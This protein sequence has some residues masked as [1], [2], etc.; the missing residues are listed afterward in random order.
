MESAALDAEFIGR[1]LSVEDSVSVG[2]EGECV[3]GFSVAGYVTDFIISCTSVACALVVICKQRSLDKYSPGVLVIRA[4]SASAMFYGVAFLSGGLAHMWIGIYHSQ[5]EMEAFTM[6]AENSG[7]IWTWLVAVTTTP[8]IYTCGLGMVLPYSMRA[9]WKPA[10]ALVAF[11][12]A[13]VEAYLVFN[14]EL[15]KL[16][17]GAPNLLVSLLASLIISIWACCRACGGEIG[18]PAIAAGSG[19]ILAAW[20]QQLFVPAGCRDQCAADFDTLCPYPKDFNQ[21]AVFHVI[22]LVGIIVQFVGVM[23]RTQSE[24][25]TE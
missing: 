20:L 17:S 23:Q 6:G 16:W 1:R 22:L 21:N 12:V 11:V 10:L 4:F 8:S 15:L 24:L 5:G 19:T 25:Y 7:W 14:T 3:F 2:S 9:V 18:M 13:A